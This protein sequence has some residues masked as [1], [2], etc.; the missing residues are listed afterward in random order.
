MQ[1]AGDATAAGIRE[2][3]SVAQQRQQEKLDLQLRISSLR[4]EMGAQ[5]DMTR[6]QA[7]ARQIQQ[8]EARRSRL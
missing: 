8:L 2:G 3:V 7:I 4:S 5:A 6:R 1:Q